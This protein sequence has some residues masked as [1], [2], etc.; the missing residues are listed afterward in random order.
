VSLA[1]LVRYATRDENDTQ[2]CGKLAAGLVGYLW[3][4]EIIVVDIVDHEDVDL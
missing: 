4:A 1:K 2:C 3:R